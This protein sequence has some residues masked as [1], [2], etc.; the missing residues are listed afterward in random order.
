MTRQQK[1][2][3]EKNI[4]KLLFPEEISLEYSFIFQQISQPDLFLTPLSATRL[5]TISS[6]NVNE[7]VL[8]LRTIVPMVLETAEVNI[9][10][11]INFLKKAAE[12]EEKIKCCEKVINRPKK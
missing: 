12:L 3:N 8:L 9:N 2:I 10:A 5:T 11:S 7:K 4:Q 1:I 6:L